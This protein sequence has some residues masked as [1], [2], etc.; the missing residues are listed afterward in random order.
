M[1][2]AFLILVLTLQFMGV[3]GWGRSLDLT[4]N[5]VGVYNSLTST[6]NEMSR[7]GV[8]LLCTT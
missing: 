4:S 5:Y 6:D 2:L 1:K 7:N 8:D 3:G